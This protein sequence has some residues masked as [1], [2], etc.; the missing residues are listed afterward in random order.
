MDN[1]PLIIGISGASGAIYGVSL[2]K[3]LREQT[4]IPT[5]LV[6]SQAGIRTLAEETTYT[7]EQVQNYASMVCSVKDIGACIASGSYATRGMIIAPCSV[8][9]MSEIAHGITSSLMSR[10]A[11]VC[12]KERRPLVL[13]IRETPF[14]SGHLRTMLELS[15]MNAIIAPP[16]PAFYHGIPTIEDMIAQICYRWLSLV[17]IELD[18]KKI[19]QG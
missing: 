19:W 16:L 11:D 17:G 15:Q 12:L 9:T 4:N 13:G 10:A 1:K 14:H 5:V 8:K 3:I 6:I 7:L 18:D 2:L